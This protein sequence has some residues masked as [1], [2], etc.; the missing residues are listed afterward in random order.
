MRTPVLALLPLVCAIAAPPSPDSL[1]DAARAM[2]AEFAA[3]ALIRIAGTDQVEKPKKIE[4]LVEAFDRAAGA[5]LPYKRRSALMHPDG[6]AG[7]WSRV[8]LQDMDVL[9]LRL[10][11]VGA[12]LPLDGEKA[13]EMFARIP[14]LKLPHASCDD[15]LV[16]DVSRFYD[17]LAELAAAGDAA[18]LIE[19]YAGAVASPVE[20]APMATVLTDARL[21]DREFETGLAAFSRALQRITGDDRSFA[22]ASTV[23]VRIQKLVAEAKK[24]QVSPLPLLEAYR[25]YLVINLSAPR[26][27]DDDLMQGGSTSLGLFTGQPS[28]E[29]G[30]DV[31]TFFNTKLL[32]PPVKRIEEQDAT[33][34]RLEGAATGL[35]MC[36]DADCQAIAKKCRGLM[37]NDIGLPYPPGERA[38]PEWQARFRAMLSTIAGWKRQPEAPA[39]EY[40]EEKTEA[41]RQLL[42]LSNDVEDRELAVRGLLDFVSGNEFQQQGRAE[43]F[44]PINGL[45]ARCG[46]DP[47]GFGKLAEE[48]RRSKDPVIALYANLEAAAPRPPDRV[49]PL[50]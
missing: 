43:W 14:P 49:L 18:P 2:P 32:M 47:M 21:G 24:R 37:V 27:A 10:R 4:L 30:E 17:V 12:L 36:Q 42:S 31:V 48:L 16:F 28:N 3:D 33:P 29:M 5:Q 9:S 20:I 1:I 25:V 19:R 40:Y 50:M 6:Q 35:R 13:R 45:I 7:Y 46:L 26:C 38:K 39:S 8:Y 11:A 22:T 41:Y 34:T 15:F 23:G 44:L